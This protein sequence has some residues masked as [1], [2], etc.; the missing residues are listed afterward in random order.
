MG[1]LEDR[2]AI[3]TGA[4]RGIG[5]ATAVAFAREGAAVTVNT[6]PGERWETMAADVVAR[7]ASLGGRAMV[8]PADVSDPG[9]VT[10]MVERTAEAFGDPDVLV[11]NAVHSVRNPWHEISVE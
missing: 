8:V 6:L 2:V 5:A 4:S 7:I 9:S 10:A 1:R 3:V 11:S